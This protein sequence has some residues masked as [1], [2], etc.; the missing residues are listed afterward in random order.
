MPPA[1]ATLGIHELDDQMIGKFSFHSR[2]SVLKVL[3]SSGEME[4]LQV[5]LMAEVCPYRLDWIKCG[6][7]VHLE[8]SQERFTDCLPAELATFAG[9]NGFGLV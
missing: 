8:C 3:S 5:S 2:D 9:P 4:N 1:M 6:G 7:Y